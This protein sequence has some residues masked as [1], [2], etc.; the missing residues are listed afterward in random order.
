[1][2]SSHNLL[3]IIRNH[4]KNLSGIQTSSIESSMEKL[5]LIIESVR[6]HQNYY[7]KLTEGY[8][9]KNDSLNTIIASKL[10]KI[11]VLLLKSKNEQR[12]YL[13]TG[14]LKHENKFAETLQILIEELKE[15]QSILE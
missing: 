9:H 4:L 6:G 15:F 11:K 13:S 1:L 8:H 12:L 3:P 2:F 14:K 10:T 7:I 5:N